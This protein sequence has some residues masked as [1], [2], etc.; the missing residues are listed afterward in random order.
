[1][2]AFGYCSAALARL[3]EVVA[4]LTGCLGRE[5]RNGG[6]SFGGRARI[7][8]ERVCPVASDCAEAGW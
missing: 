3:A 6:D 2:V 8:A 5:E 4:A 1:M 7:F